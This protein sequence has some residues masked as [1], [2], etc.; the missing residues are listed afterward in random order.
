MSYVFLLDRS[1]DYPTTHLSI[2]RHEYHFSVVFKNIY[3]ALEQAKTYILSTK[4]QAFITQHLYAII[5]MLLNQSPI[6]LGRTKDTYGMTENEY[7][8]K[9]IRFALLLINE[10]LRINA[11]KFNKQCQTIEALPHVLDNKNI[12][13]QESEEPEDVRFDKLMVFQ[14]IKGF[15]YL[16]IYFEVRCNTPSFPHW[17]LVYRALKASY[18][19]FVYLRLYKEDNNNNDDY[20]HGDNDAPAYSSHHLSTTFRKESQGLALAVMKHVKGMKPDTIS[21]MD[22]KKLSTITSVLKDLHLEYA[23]ADSQKMPEYFA[24]VREMVVKLLLTRS[25]AHKTFGQKLLHFLIQSIYGMKSIPTAFTVTGAGR[26]MVNGTYYLSPCKQD[27]DGFVIPGANPRYERFHYDTGKK[28]VLLRSMVEGD[29]KM[30]SLS[31]EHDDD[32]IPS[33]YTDYY[34]IMHHNTVPPLTD[35]VS[36]EEIDDPPP[37]LEHLS[38]MAHVR[39]AHQSLKYDLARWFLE[40]NV[41]NSILDIEA[42]VSTDP[43]SV[44]KLAEAMDNFINDGDNISTVTP[45]TNDLLVSILPQIYNSSINST[46]SAIPSSKAAYDAAKLR[47]ASAERWHQTTARTLLT[48]QTEHNSSSKELEEARSAVRELE[49]LSALENESLAET[50]LE[51]NTSSIT[52]DETLILPTT[53]PKRRTRSKLTGSTR[54]TISQAVSGRLRRNLGATV[55]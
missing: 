47:L 26:E 25:V 22:V 46:T 49:W 38:E 18:E 2:R 3:R 50:E 23:L 28:M 11:H 33:E 40:N 7:V 41:T 31:E 37:I 44:S 1:L 15:Y 8:D 17:E 36:E 12:Y 20:D 35:W 29:E 55:I 9:S 13:Y 30:W 6:D 27:S 51:S 52:H 34:T 53:M 5:T 32:P 43:Y 54:A 48:A 16:S 21:K 4:A 42:S 10:D 24:F 39:E 14:R 45:K 19:G